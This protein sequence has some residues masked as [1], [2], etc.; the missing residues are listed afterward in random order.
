MIPFGIA[1]RWSP[2][3]SL[4]GLRWPHNS[5][6]SKYQCCLSDLTVLL[7]NLIC[8]RR[9]ILFSMPTKQFIVSSTTSLVVFKERRGRENKELK[10]KFTLMFKGWGELHV[11]TDTARTI[12]HRFNGRR[13][14][15]LFVCLFV[16]YCGKNISSA[17]FDMPST[18]TLIAQPIAMVQKKP[19]GALNVSLFDPTCH[20][21]I[22]DSTPPLDFS[23]KWTQSGLSLN[24]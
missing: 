13:S 2:N 9:E 1:R 22:P 3:L 24:P 19:A 4:S 5:M 15:L 10:G 6:T 16:F 8:H 12:S 7:I 20:V 21:V 14:K 17:F 23:R 18:L 11:N